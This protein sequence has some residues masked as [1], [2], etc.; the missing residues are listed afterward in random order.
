MGIYILPKQIMYLWHS[1]ANMV[2]FFF[3]LADMVGNLACD[4]SMY[5]GGFDPIACGK[6][7]CVSFVLVRY[8]M[9]GTKLI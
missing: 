1:I 4:S 8:N 2:L 9:A 3:F 7:N 6:N 5:F